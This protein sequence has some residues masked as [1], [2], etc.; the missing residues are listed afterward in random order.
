MHRAAL[1]S[2]ALLS[3]G[4]YALAQDGINN[5]QTNAS[6]LT[7][8]TLAAARG[9]AGTIN[10]ALAGN[11]SGVVSQA[12][13]ANLSDVTAPATW[14]PTDASGAALTLAA[15][16]AR[17]T[18]IGNIVFAYG[19]VTYPATADGSAAKIGSLPVTVPNA[20]YATQCTVSWSD[21]STLAFLTPTANTVTMTLFQHGAGGITNA[22]MSGKSIAFQCI[23]PAA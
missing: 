9:G 11:G 22:N 13:T 7:T 3:A 10:G 12:A 5:P 4:L 20:S 14:T 1:V 17:Y 21:L 8:G 23:Y 18:K 2:I 19:F 6:A 16:N 15:A